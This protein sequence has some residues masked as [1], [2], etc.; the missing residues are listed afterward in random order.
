MSFVLGLLISL[1]HAD[2]WHVRGE[3]SRFALEVVLRPKSAR[4]RFAPKSL[5]VEQ[6]LFSYTPSAT[7]HTP[8]ELFY[9]EI[10]GRERFALS[11]EDVE[12]SAYGK[13]VATPSA[14]V[15]GYYL[16]FRIKPHARGRVRGYRY[17][18]LGIGRYGDP[19][20]PHHVLLLNDEEDNSAERFKPSLWHRLFL[21]D[22][23]FLES[24]LECERLLDQG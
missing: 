18:A 14:G 13:G 5:I 11:A 17:L 2:A 10:F 9:V 4:A 19:Q 6:F 23:L 16:K 3:N 7:S 20:P 15:N 12:L 1:G 8:R 24:I 22:K 21:G